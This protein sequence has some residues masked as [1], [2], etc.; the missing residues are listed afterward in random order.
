V[1]DSNIIARPALPASIR[2][3]DTVRTTEAAQT[4]KRQALSR[5]GIQIGHRVLDVG[6]G[7]GDD[8]RAIARLVGAQG[9]VI[10]VDCD[11]Q[12]IAEAWR[13]LGPR[14]DK[15]NVEFK[16]CDA[17]SL[18]FDADSFD[19]CYSDRLFQ[20]L[21]NP[22]LALSEMI[23]VVVSG[24][25][26]VV[27]DPD[28]E[29]LTIDVAERSITR[30]IVQ[31]VAD[32]FVRNGWMGR[33]LHRLFKEQAL[34]DIQVDPAIVTATSFEHAE[35]LW[36]LRLNASRARDAGVITG[37]Q[38]ASWLHDLEAADQSSLFFAAQLGFVVSGKKP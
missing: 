30:R 6:C 34:V 22:A 38:M 36:S 3:L 14:Y 31:F 26:L 15:R 23:R 11:Y 17:H 21:A 5:A 37:E 35:T 27:S 20:H 33:Q 10:G 1:T 4:Y 18:P 19:V 32:H 9:K 8:V 24:A 7:P 28:W 12:M 13:R 16:V 2:Y 25:G 29:T